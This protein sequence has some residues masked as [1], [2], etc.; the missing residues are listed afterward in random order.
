MGMTAHAVIV[1]ASR[2]ESTCASSDGGPGLK[3]GAH[4]AGR[5]IFGTKDVPVFE[6]YIKKRCMQTHKA[7]I[8]LFE[9]W[10][11]DLSLDS[12][13]DCGFAETH[14]GRAVS[15]GDGTDVYGEISPF[16]CLATVWAHLLSEKAFQISPRVQSL[17]YLCVEVRG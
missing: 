3:R 14:E 9:V 11:C 8:R 17:E 16:L 6:R 12:A 15:G 1:D 13:D 10:L 7:L 4:K 2:S 5:S